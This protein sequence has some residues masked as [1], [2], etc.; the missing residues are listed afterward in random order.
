MGITDGT[1]P[2]CVRSGAGQPAR[3]AIANL[4]P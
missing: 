2:V 1:A 4:P 3:E